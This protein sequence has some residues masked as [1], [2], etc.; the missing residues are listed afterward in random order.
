MPK[1]PEDMSSAA[2]Q[3]RAAITAAEREKA[4]AKPIEPVAAKP[5]IAKKR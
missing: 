1:T 4:K 5:I 2:I 3:R